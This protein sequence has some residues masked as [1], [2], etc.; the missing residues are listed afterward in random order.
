MDVKTD[1]LPKDSVMVENGWVILSGE[2]DWQY[3]RQAAVDAVRDLMGVTG[4]CDQIAV[5]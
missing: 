1:D 3:Q 4:V 2:V 5:V